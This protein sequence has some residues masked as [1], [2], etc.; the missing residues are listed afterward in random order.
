MTNK[1]EETRGKFTLVGKVAGMDRQNAYSEDVQQDGNYAGKK[2]RR[3]NIGIR[4]SDTNEIF[5]GMFSFLPDKVY[6]WDNKERKTVNVPYETWK[7]NREGFESNKQIPLQSNINLSGTP[8]HLPSWD[9]MEYINQN[10]NNGDS[11]RVSGDISYN[12]YKNKQTGD[13]VTSTNYNITNVTKLDTPL[14]FEAEDFVEVNT[15]RQ[16]FVYVDGYNDEEDKKFRI[17]GY[18]INYREDYVPV[19]L[20]IDYEGD[21]DLKRM[22]KAYEQAVD[23]GALID[24]YGFILNRAVEDTVTEDDD[25]DLD[26]DDDILDALLGKDDPNP[27]AVF[28]YVREMQ[29][30]GAESV[31]KDYYS[32]EDFTAEGD[33]VFDEEVEK[34][35]EESDPLLGKSPASTMDFEADNAFDDIDVEGDDLPF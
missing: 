29:M 3:L 21:D 23:F 35:D 27:T 34:E 4:T 5:V 30:T 1:L 10:L 17:D 9:A 18:A 32:D 7:N 31:E 33:S 25:F 15:F 12:Q 2:R 28:T 20:V 26:F 22:A 24:S 14:D 11:V 6:L 13:M 19:E 8:Q 16:P